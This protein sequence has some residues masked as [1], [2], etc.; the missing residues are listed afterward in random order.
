MDTRDTPI[1]TPKPGSDTISSTCTI[2]S[3]SEPLTLVIFGASGDL[4]A[5][6][7]FPAVYNL[8]RSKTMAKSLLIL[9]VGRSEFSS[10]TLREKIRTSLASEQDIAEDV[11]N[12]LAASIFYSQLDYTTL[13]DY[14]DLKQTLQALDPGRHT[15]GN[16]LFYLAVPPTSYAT[17]ATH[18]G[19][20][21]LS[22]EHVDGNG[23]I[24]LV[25]EKPFGR[26]LETARELD[27]TLH[28]WFKEHQI[29][30][31][32]HYMAKETVQNVLMF[33]F[34]NAI[35]EPIWNRSYIDHIEITASETLGVE[36]RAGYYD[37]AG[38]LRDMFQNHMMMLLALCAMEPPSLFES[39][40]VRDERSKVYRALRPFPVDRIDEQLVLGQYASGIVQDRPVNGYVDEPGVP[41]RSMTPT[42][43]KMKVFIDNW[44]WQGVPILLTSGKRMHEKRTEIAV[45]FKEVPCSMFHHL[46]GEHIA[47]NRLIL[48][49]HPNECVDLTFQTKAPGTRICLRPVTMHFDYTRG[50]EGPL[51]DA[52]EKI[53]LDC[54]LGD[55]TLFWRQDAVE[56]CWSFLTPILTECDCP[57]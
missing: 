4:S 12:V 52:Y 32:D 57:E 22:R 42:Y 53:L 7:V 10:F 47:A 34:A 25:V 3:V 28:A 37:R 16:I 35:F 46:L 21:G 54:M 40:R 31:I 24:R 39:E 13:K 33:R 1:I 17:I 8:V 6:K 50:Y 56:L 27:S 23:R 44:R 15:Q 45:Q 43:A 26:D 55:Q 30:R 20:V 11:W 29:F 14:E 38:V 41:S 5:R 48:G 36:H 19:Q 18:L 49:I 9:G 51:L 2:E